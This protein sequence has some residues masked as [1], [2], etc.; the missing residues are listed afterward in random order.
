L[1][2]FGALEVTAKLSRLYCRQ[3]DHES[4]RFGARTFALSEELVIGGESDHLAHC[5]DWDASQVGNRERGG[6]RALLLFDTK[7]GV[8]ELVFPSAT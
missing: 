4:P 6:Y 3:A 8:E 1:R 5:A 2:T 7:T